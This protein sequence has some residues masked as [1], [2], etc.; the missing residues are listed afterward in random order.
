M[1]GYPPSAECEDTQHDQVDLESN[2]AEDTQGSC[3]VPTLSPHYTHPTGAS[4]AEVLHLITFIEQSRHCDVTCRLEEEEARGLKEDN[5]R[6]HEEEARCSVEEASYYSFTCS[7]SDFYSYIYNSYDF[8][9][10]TYSLYN[11]YISGRGIAS[12]PNFNGHPGII[13]DVVNYCHSYEATQSTASAIHSSSS[14]L[15]T[16]SSYKKKKHQTKKDMD[17]VN[18]VHVGMAQ[19]SAPLLR[20]LVTIVA[21][22][23]IGPMLPTAPQ[24]M[25]SATFVVRQDTITSA[26][27][28]G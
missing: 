27:Q 20:A 22:G 24:R 7:F 2:Q 5:R 6:R 13:T 16:I 4:D 28:R 23:V 19:G 26:A 15:S 21:I 18:F 11:C 8:Y 9:S 25:P 3:R 12:A 1:E 17:P 10:Y 14:Q